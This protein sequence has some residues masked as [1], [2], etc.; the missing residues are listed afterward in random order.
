MPRSRGSRA[1]KR[2]LDPRAPGV[3]LEYVGGRA[4]KYVPA[5]DLEGPDLAR[6]A[7]R[8]AL[9]AE[10]AGRSRLRR[11]DEE[12]ATPRRPDPADAAG[13]LAVADELVASGAFAWPKTTQPE[14]EP[15]AEPE[16]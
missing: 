15:P 9:D 1:V 13:A 8:R 12:P 7:Y 14:P 10:R 3:V 11:Q 5:R 4:R 2:V 16:A 6:I